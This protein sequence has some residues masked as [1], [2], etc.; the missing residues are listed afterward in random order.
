MFTSRRSCDAAGQIAKRSAIFLSIKMMT[1]LACSTNS[2]NFNL[3]PCGHRLCREVYVRSELAD[4][5]QAG[6]AI[7]SGRLGEQLRLVAVFMIVR[8]GHRSPMYTLP[9]H[10]LPDLNCHLGHVQ[11]SDVDGA[12]AA[13]FIAAMDAVSRRRESIHPAW[14]RY[15]LYPASASCS[16]AQ[17]T[18]AGALQMLRLGLQL[19]RRGYSELGRSGVVVRASEYSRTVQSAAALLYGLGGQTTHLV[20][21]ATVELSRD[22]YLCLDKRRASSSSSSNVT[23]DCRAALTTLALRRRYNR[24]SSVAERRLRTEIASILNVT[25]S[26][27]PWT[28]AVLEVS[29]LPPSNSNNRSTRQSDE[30]AQE[31]SEPIHRPH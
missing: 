4:C 25:A 22:T 13:D 19:R 31:L 2:G 20:D 3:I 5:R 21:S 6:C 14:Q 26:R 9:G 24:T 15:G 18:A 7:W 27:L 28:A 29:V 8:H 16:G 12:Q 17:L 11:S 10:R 30:P 23:C 1:S